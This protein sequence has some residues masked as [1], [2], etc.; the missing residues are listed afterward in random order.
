MRCACLTLLF[1]LV[2]LVSLPCVA[3]EEGSG[4]RAETARLPYHQLTWSDFRIDDVSQGFSA[5]T[6]TFLSYGYSARVT[7]REGQFEATVLKI[8][9]AGGLDRTKSWRRSSVSL[10]DAQLLEHEQ[11][12]LDINELKVRQLQAL[13]PTYLTTGKG[14]T[15]KTALNDLNVRLAAFQREQTRDL[16]RTQKRY[17]AETR[18]GTDRDRQHDWNARLRQALKMMPAR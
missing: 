13:G 15:A 16:D 4:G 9:F 11:G 3:R 7:W 17:D 2:L 10:D 18:F 1:A 14:S 6:E 8:T 12:H 5:Q